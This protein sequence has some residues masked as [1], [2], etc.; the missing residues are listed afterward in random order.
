MISTEVSSLAAHNTGT[1]TLLRREG[2]YS[3]PI[4]FSTA[5]YANKTSRRNMCRADI[6]NT[7][8]CTMFTVSE[9]KSRKSSITSS[10]VESGR[11]SLIYCSKVRMNLRIFPSA[12]NEAISS[13]SRLI[14]LSRDPTRKTTSYRRRTVSVGNLYI[15]EVGDLAA[16]V[17]SAA[18]AI[19]L[20]L[21][22]SSRAARESVPLA[23]LDPAG[24]ESCRS[25]SMG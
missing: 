9:K 16:V 15:V 17:G 20:A 1:G 13:S 10:F 21:L 12:A 24:A 25:G 2:T 4:G 19:S 14:L 11:I 3:P 6:C 7:C 18:A 23:S 22:E 5:P 8:R